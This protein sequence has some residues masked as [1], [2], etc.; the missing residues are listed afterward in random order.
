MYVSLFFYF[1]KEIVYFC[2]IKLN[3]SQMKH[4]KL[5]LL[6][7]LILCT[8]LYSNAQD[9]GRYVQPNLE[10][11]SEITIEKA[12]NL[13]LHYCDY[14]DF[15][16]SGLIVKADV[17]E[18]GFV[19]FLSLLPYVS[20]KSEAF[21]KLYAKAGQNA[22]MLSHFID[23]TTKY[24][25]EMDSP[26][27]DE[28][29]YIVALNQLLACDKVSFDDK[30]RVGYYL[31][32]VMKNRVGHKATNFGFIQK[33][34]KRRS[35]YG[36]KADYILLYFNDPTCDECHKLKTELILSPIISKK[37]EEGKLKVLSVCVE[38]N[39]DEWKTQSLPH[40][41]IDACDERMLITDRELY[42]LPSLPVLYLL[43]RS[44]R[45]VQKNTNVEKLEIFF[46]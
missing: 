15:N 25:Y 2:V 45:V 23:M 42:D 3:S 4:L 5:I 14:F 16:D 6:S 43:D 17:T 1:L 30:E 36:V 31:A 29:L 20:K 28:E 19:N 32:K 8:N 26:L 7:V 39:K 35:L 33:Q 34:Y 21:A 12:D 13:V 11:M 22:E 24:L 10:N 18:Q 27:C 44:Y 37:V 46:E 40:Q 41:W 38:G 9:S